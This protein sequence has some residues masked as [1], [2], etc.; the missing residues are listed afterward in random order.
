MRTQFTLKL[1]FLSIPFPFS[2][3][4]YVLD[5]AYTPSNFFN[6]FNH[7]TGDDPTSGFVNY[8][9][10]PTAF[11]SGFMKDQANSIYIGVDSDTIY[12]INARGRPSVRL[13]SKATYTHGLFVLD[14][15]HLPVGCGVWP[16]WWTVGKDWPNN[17]EIDILEGV[18]LMTANKPSAHTS[19]GC[20]ITGS[21][22]TATLSQPDCSPAAP[23]NIGCGS[24][25]VEPNSYGAGFNAAGG[26]IYAMEWTSAAI[27]IWFWPHG[28]VPP[29]LYT[30]NPKPDEFGIPGASFAGPGCDIDEH[31]KQHQ[32]VF[33]TTFCGAYGGNTFEANGC[34]M[35]VPGDG[36]GS[37]VAYVAGHPEEMKEAF[38]D[39]NSLHVFKAV[40]DDVVV[41]STPEAPTS[42]EVP[43]APW[44]VPEIPVSTSVEIILPT[45][46]LEVPDT[47]TSPFVQA[48][49]LPPPWFPDE[50][51]VFGVPPFKEAPIVPPPEGYNGVKGFYVNYGGKEFYSDYYGQ[52]G[53]DSGVEDWGR[54]SAERPEISEIAETNEEDG[55]GG[56]DE[57]VRDNDDNDNE[58]TTEVTEEEEKDEQEEEEKENGFET[59]SREEVPDEDQDEDQDEEQEPLR[60]L[61]QT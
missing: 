11:S 6:E 28:S 40:A 54:L 9:D 31:F 16:A 12:P 23:G 4:K 46:T 49:I 57:A 37:C 60:R 51:P 13:E 21:N 44:E 53:V 41:V 26:G 5:H 59:E 34:P 36:L 29:S 38:W 39:I 42:V 17:G 14:L 56:E 8:V 7:F 30:P 58:E 25:M 52:H 55:D 43:V 61:K 48:S 10:Q 22:Q 20:T 3:A 50:P 35:S 32:I 2:T 47:T 19:A 15:N 33:D 18:N 45:T 24:A 1:V 27:R